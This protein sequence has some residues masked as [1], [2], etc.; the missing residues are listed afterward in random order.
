MP[1][2]TSA[3]DSLIPHSKL[4]VVGSPS[5]GSGQANWCSPAAGPGGCHRDVAAVATGAV[6]S[7]VQEC[8]DREPHS[9][10]TEYMSSRPCAHA[11]RTVPPAFRE[12]MHF[13]VLK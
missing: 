2:I 11:D 6:Q 9:I 1:T 4:Q 10:A 7:G 12:T 8:P 5:G 3:S 13:L